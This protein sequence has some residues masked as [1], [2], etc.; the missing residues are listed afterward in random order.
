MR[1]RRKA[2]RYNLGQESMLHP[3][4]GGVGS[5]AVVRVL[6]TLGCAV[7]CEKPP[8]S[9]KK[10]ELYFDSDFGQI[11]VEAQAV[12]KDP[13]S[14]RI[15]LKFLSLDKDMA[16]RLSDLCAALQAQPAAAAGQEVP[17]APAPEPVAAAPVS[18]KPAVDPT[19]AK[20]R[21]RRRVPR[22]VSEMRAKVSVVPGDGS[23]KVR[24][25]TLSVL[26]CCMEGENL[27]APAATCEVSADWD[28]RML[29]LSGEVKWKKGKQA[30]VKFISLD[31]AAE[32][33]L[34]HICANLR[35]QPLAPLPPEPA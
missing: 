6:S 13:A 21:E 15:G 18:A 27:P 19:V 17:S 20:E 9:G 1:E 11:G 35:L 22:Y 12:S 31:E 16:R 29:H 4:E 5:R 30:G 34:R 24:L 25:I 23:S 14:G 10:C 7:E 33:L 2:L 26:G 3:P 8:V 28:G 32:R